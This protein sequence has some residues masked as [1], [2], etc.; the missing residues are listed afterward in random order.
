MKVKEVCRQRHLC[1]K[2]RQFRVRQRI[3]VDMFIVCETTEIGD[4]AGTTEIGDN[5]GT[6]EIGDNAGTTEI[7]E[8]AGTNEGSRRRTVQCCVQLGCTSTT[9]LYI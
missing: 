1:H 2:T 3:K 7:G 9:W 8:T 6:T 4:T 5:G